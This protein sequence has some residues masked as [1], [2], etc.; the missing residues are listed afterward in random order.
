MDIVQDSSYKVF[1]KLARSLGYP[2]PDYVAEYTAEQDK[3]ASELPESLFACPARREYPVDSKASTWL[4]AMYVAAENTKTAEDAMFVIKASAAVWGISDDVDK[5]IAAVGS[6]SVKQASAPDDSDYG[7]IDRDANGKVIAR[8]YGIFD[9]AGVMKAASYFLENRDSYHYR[10]REKVASF[11]VKKAA[12]YGVSREVL[13][14][15]IEKEAGAGIPVKAVIKSELEERARLAKHA[16]C[17]E[18]LANVNKVLD[19]CDPAELP[20]AIDKIASLVNEYDMAEDLVQHYGKRITRPS[21]FLRTMDEKTA[22]DLVD[23]AVYIDGYAFDYV[24]LAELVPSSEF[25]AAMGPG[26]VAKIAESGEFSEEN[27]GGNVK[28]SAD[29]LKQAINELAPGKQEVL[30]RHLVALCG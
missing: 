18:L 26:F 11:I 24:K 8:R 19:A 27:D 6:Q 13:G 22:A 15:D 23:K 3:I 17:G 16:D 25:Y 9:K 21:E 2:L 5:V 1:S 29:K 20:E 14:P 30:Q 10:T 4:S 28:I 12:E 7:W